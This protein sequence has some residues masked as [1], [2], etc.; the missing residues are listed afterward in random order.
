M[1]TTGDGIDT[2]TQGTLRGKHFRGDADDR[3]LADSIYG[4]VGEGLRPLRMDPLPVSLGLRPVSFTDGL[5][6][7]SVDAIRRKSG[8]PTPAPIGESD[9]LHLARKRVSDLGVID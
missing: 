8:R 4:A 9:A 1:Q 5:E 3:P 2:R 7:L 6:E